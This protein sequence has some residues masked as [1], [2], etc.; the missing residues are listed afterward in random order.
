MQKGNAIYAEIPPNAIPNCKHHLEEGKIVYMGKITVERAKQY[1][2]VV[3]HPYMIRLNKFTLIQEA[4]NYPENFPKYT[5]SLTP[6]TDLPRYLRS[7]E[8]F[9]GMTLYFTNLKLFVLH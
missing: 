2:K 8:K 5:F 6:F 3:D 9:L 7:K 1:F 4:N